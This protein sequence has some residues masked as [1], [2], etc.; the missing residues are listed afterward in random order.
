MLSKKAKYGI[1]ALLFL[2]QR[3]GNEPVPIHR[4]ADSETSPPNS[5][6]AYCSS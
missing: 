1:N 5:L 3:E 2:A 6:R 4:I